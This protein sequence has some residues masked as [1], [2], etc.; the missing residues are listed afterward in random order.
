M[1]RYSQKNMHD[2]GPHAEAGRRH[3]RGI[4]TAALGVLM[5]WTLVAPGV[6]A[7]GNIPGADTVM[8]MAAASGEG[9]PT[10]PELIRERDRENA[11]LRQELRELRDRHAR[12]LRQRDEA[13]A[14][15]GAA[16]D[17]RTADKRD[18]ERRE[19][20]AARFTDFERQTRQELEALREALRQRESK[21]EELE[22][23]MVRLRR[24]RDAVVPPDDPSIVAREPSPVASVADDAT[25]DV[26]PDWHKHRDLHYNRGVQLARD[27]H[28]REAEL[29]Y[30]AA[31]RLDPWDAGT[32]YNLGLLYHHQLSQPDRAVAHYR[33]YLQ[34]KPHS[35]HA[36]AVRRRLRALEMER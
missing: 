17:R 11:R 15:L 5:F 14:L 36:A 27:G 3:E 8:I 23:T 25:P 24:D 29:E 34:Q 30:L 2:S 35:S 10:V 31:L 13:L 16:M 7:S 32:H 9:E 33:A 28:G 18:R 4:L 1:K 21:I 26:S 22:Q 12:K 6:Q 19:E 20:V